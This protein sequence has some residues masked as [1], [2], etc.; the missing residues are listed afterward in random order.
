ML[1]AQRYSGFRG[2]RVFAICASLIMA[3]LMFIL[4][5][6]GSNV[7]GQGSTFTLKSAAGKCA[8]SNGVQHYIAPRPPGNATTYACSDVKLQ[9]DGLYVFSCGAVGTVIVPMP[10]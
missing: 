8:I 7:G 9:T 2:N 5:A 10:K 4:S 1:R 3:L 6:C